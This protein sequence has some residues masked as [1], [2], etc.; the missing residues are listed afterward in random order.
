MGLPPFLLRNHFTWNGMEWNG[1]EW[2]KGPVLPSAFPLPA[3]LFLLAKQN[4]AVMKGSTCCTL[5]KES[6]ALVPKCHLEGILRELARM[7]LNIPAFLPVPSS[8]NAD[9]SLQYCPICL[10]SPNF[11]YV[12]FIR[13][14]FSSYCSNLFFM[15]L[16]KDRFI[17]FRVTVYCVPSLIYYWTSFLSFPSD[18]QYL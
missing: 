18:I 3:N 5:S 7:P 17:R 1:M 16:A 10:N 12:F 4:W 8:L 2:R 9:C 11:P 14:S 6:W 15:S 13:T